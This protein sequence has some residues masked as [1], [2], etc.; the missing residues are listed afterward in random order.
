MKK[1]IFMMIALFSMAINA[2]AQNYANYSGS[3]KFTDNVSVTLG[4]GVVTPMED[5][6]ANGSTTPIVVLGVDK[7]INPWLGVGVEGRTSIGVGDNYNPHTAFDYVNVSTYLKLNVLNMI[8]F[9][10]QRRVFEP[11]L[12]GGLG[13]GHAN[14]SVVNDDYTRLGS[15][16][17][18]VNARNFMT[19][20]AGAELNFYFNSK[21]VKGE[22]SGWSLN[23]TPS[24]VWGDICNGRLDKRCGYFEVTAGVRYTFKSSNGRR[25]MDASP[26]PALVA[27]NAALVAENASLTKALDE[28]RSTVKTVEVVKE[29]PATAAV[30]TVA[31]VWTITF[32]F[33]STKLTDAA[34]ATLDTIPTNTVVTVEGFASYE[35][36]SNK[37]HND[38]LSAA[39][40]I[41]VADYLTARGVKIAETVGRGADSTSARVAIVST[42]L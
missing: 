30:A 40:A 5:F 24:V 3:S 20:R 8:K 16:H 34:K 18:A 11:V 23:V 9:N 26:V 22:K 15:S 4:G 21:K 1:F 36:K 32:E 28:A 19:G 35:K 41:V 27:D 37:K 2:N 33:D 29:V 25:V 12:F 17:T 10:G 39:R 38:A 14:C 13:W 31:D 42:K 6:F 7:F